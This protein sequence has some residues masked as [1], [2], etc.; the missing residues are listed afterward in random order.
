MKQNEKTFKYESKIKFFLLLLLCL[1]I[2]STEVKGEQLLKL[3]NSFI[4]PPLTPLVI[5]GVPFSSS[6]IV[7]D[8]IMYAPAVDYLTMIGAKSYLQKLPDQLIINGQMAPVSLLAT[9]PD[10]YTGKNIYYL[11]VTETL[12]FLGLYYKV[13]NQNGQVRITVDELSRITPPSEKNGSISGHV[14]YPYFE[15]G[16]VRLKTSYT[17]NARIPQTKEISSAY[18]PSDGYYNFQDLPPG[19]YIVEASCFYTTT[20]PVVYD[21]I[22]RQVYRCVTT[23]TALWQIRVTTKEGEKINQDFLADQARVNTEDKLIYLGNLPGTK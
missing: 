15:G 12:N 20:G 9:G 17:N 13:T 4:D 8:N 19:D 6:V 11:N 21:S 16:F 1:T 7:Q 18:L 14:I 5:Y 22:C 2:F 10:R 3:S 23:Y